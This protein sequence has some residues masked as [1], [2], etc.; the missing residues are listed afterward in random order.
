MREIVGYANRGGNVTIQATGVEHIPN[1]NG[2]IMYPNHQG[3]YD[4]LA[5]EHARLVESGEAQED[6]ALYEI[7]RREFDIMFR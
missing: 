2:F 7:Y 5:A 4:M 1:E 6:P 3:M